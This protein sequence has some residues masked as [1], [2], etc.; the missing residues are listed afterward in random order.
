MYGI[1]RQLSDDELCR[2]GDQISAE[3]LYGDR[4]H[5]SMSRFKLRS[6][7]RAAMRDKPREL[8][9]SI[10]SILVRC[11]EYLNVI[12]EMLFFPLKMG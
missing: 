7:L 9:P 12:I 5:L 3:D 4:G 2:D 10:F 1:E 8:S 11:V 6:A